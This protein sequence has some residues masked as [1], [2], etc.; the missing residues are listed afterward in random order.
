MSALLVTSM[1]ST[2]PWVTVGVFVMAGMLGG[3]VGYLMNNVA[4]K[5]RKVEFLKSL[6]FGVCVSG[7]GVLLLTMLYSELFI[8]SGQDLLNLMLAGCI[9]FMLSVVILMFGYHFIMRATS[10]RK[11]QSSQGQAA[12][13]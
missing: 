13:R 2:Q 12:V 6:L 9:C 1:F 10:W 4:I 3:F 11:P 8:P 7:A 5:W